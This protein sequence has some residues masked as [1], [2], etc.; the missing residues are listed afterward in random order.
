MT[1]IRIVATNTSADGGT[2]LTPLWF[3][4][5]DGSFDLYNM[6]EA[7][8]A[9]LEALAEDGNFAPINGEVTAGDADAVTGAVVGAGGPIAT[10]ETASVLVEVDGA[11]NGY[12]SLAAMILPSND[13]FVGTGDSIA[14]FDYYGDFL[15][16]QTIEFAG[17]DV[18]DAGTEE[19]TEE[20][21]AFLNQAAPDTGVDENGVVDYH[22][23]FLPEGDGN[24][25]GGT[26]AAGAF[27][28]PVAADFTQP[29]AQIASVHINVAVITD[30]TNGHDFVGGS[31]ADDLVDGGAGRDTLIGRAGWD[32]LLGGGGNDTLS[33]GIGNDVLDGGR[34]R[35]MLDG[36]RGQDVFVFAEN[37]SRDRVENF[38]ATEDVIILDIDGVDNFDDLAGLYSQVPNNTV[39]DFGD[40]D[41]LI[42]NGTSFD[43][44]SASNFDFV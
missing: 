4:A 18:L 29:G 24:I 42:L 16:E 2:F 35:D 5:H 41:V 32:V 11:S 14:L 31:E 15:G 25:L 36:G 1:Q 21:A 17:S 43:E 19:N 8:S 23:G 33:G 7:A 3:A 37:Y 13:A 12:L 27:I 34:G 22:V 6:G 38:D 20:D 39:F 40:G 26:N 30:G 44:L 9:G 28:D 10:G